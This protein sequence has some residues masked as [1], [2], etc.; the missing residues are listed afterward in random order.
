MDPKQFGSQ[1]GLSTT[2]YLVRLLDTIYKNLERHDVWL[3]LLLIDL[4]KPF[5]LIYHNV[6][7]EKLL[8]EF[9]VNPNLVRIIASFLPS[10]TQCVQYKNAYSD[11]LPVYYGVSQG[12]PL[13]LLLFLIMI[14]ELATEHPDR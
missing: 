1:R 4:K 11:L 10:R 3:N 12:T 8:K 13:G 5:D 6:L 9:H 2:H 14:N 7:V